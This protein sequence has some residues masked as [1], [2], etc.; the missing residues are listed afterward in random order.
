MYIPTQEERYSKAPRWAL[1]LCLLLPS[2]VVMGFY[3]EVMDVFFCLSAFIQAP[4]YLLVRAG[5]NDAA[6]VCLSASV[7]ALVFFLLTRRSSGG[8]LSPKAKFTICITWGMALALLLR[9][10]LAGWFGTLS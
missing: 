9:L 2:A 7:Q 8:L 1:L 6:A 4:A 5:C 10:Q 3:G